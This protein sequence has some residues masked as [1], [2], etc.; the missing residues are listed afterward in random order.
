MIYNALL[1][2]G[3]AD[4]SKGTISLTFQPTDPG[5][6]H[7]PNLYS[8]SVSATVPPGV[9]RLASDFQRPRVQE[10]NVGIEQ[11]LTRNLSIAVSYVHSYGDRLPITLDANLPA[12][13]FTRTYQLPNGTTFT[14]PFSAGPLSNPNL[15]RPNPAFGSIT[16]NESIGKT[17]YNAMFVE[18]KRRFAGGFQGGISY[19]LAKA[20]NLAGSDSGGG[21]GAEG[22]FG[23]GSLNNQFN[24]NSNRGIAPTD[25]RHRAV[26][27][28][29]WDEPFG[30]RSDSWANALIR[31]Y[32]FSS[33]VTLESG[34]PYGAYLNTSNIPF[35]GTDGVQYNGFGGIYGQNGDTALPT[36]PRNGVYGDAN[37]RVDLRVARLFRATEKLTIEVFAEGFNIFNYSNLNGFNNTIYNVV[38][39]PSATSINT[40]VQLTPAISTGILTYGLPNADGSQPDGTNARRFQLAMR[41][42]F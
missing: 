32:R 11:Q 36:I 8:G 5:A 26:L 41:F 10:T 14:E 27:N 17:W 28:G 25:Q 9:Y 29:V 4:P 31:N 38:S 3:F 37:Y 20:E 39:T 22:P 34:R 30:R 7:Y 23:G 15:A 19:T 6:P 42:R 12:P 33:I 18:V 24:L 40:P 21:A 35:T 16:V 1:Q 2:T 13:Q